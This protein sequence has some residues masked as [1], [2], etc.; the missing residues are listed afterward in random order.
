MEDDHAENNQY[1][2]M[3]LYFM[4]LDADIDSNQKIIES[5]LKNITLMS[6]QNTI[7]VKLLYYLI[8]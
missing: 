8:F 5:V 3:L 4:L 6:L 2:L 7:V 1:K